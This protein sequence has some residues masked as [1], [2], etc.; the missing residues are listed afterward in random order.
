[1]NSMREEATT[2]AALARKEPYPDLM[3]SVWFNQ[4]MGAPNTMGAMVGATIPVFGASRGQRRGAAFDARA[5]GARQDQQAMRAMI[6]FQVADALTKFEAAKRQLDLVRTVASPKAR[7]SFD[8]SLAAFGGGTADVV[9]VLDAR[10]ALQSVEL[11]LEEA[12]IR[13]EV[14]LAELEHAVGEPLSGGAP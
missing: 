14:A 7:E 1:M 12:Q 5:E 10:R 11:T 4:M 3:A 9:G 6:A 8:S 2:M 13:R